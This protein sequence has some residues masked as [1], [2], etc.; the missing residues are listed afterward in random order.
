VSADLESRLERV[1]DERYHHL[2][3]FNLR[4]HAGE[5]SRAEIRTWV[6]NRYYYQTRIPKKDGLIVTK[7]DDPAFRRDWTRRIRDHEGEAGRE[8]GLELWL[9]L[10]EAVGLDREQVAMCRDVL[11]G[12]RRACDAY[13]EFVASHDLLESVAASL[14]ERRA[15]AIMAVRIEAWEK[16][17]SWVTPDGLAYFRSRTE[18]APRD[19]R[20]GLAY[21]LEHAQNLSDADRCVAALE[22]KC[23]ILWSLLDAIEW[24][25]RAPSLTPGM[26][27]RDDP[28]GDSLAV[29]AERAVRLND[30]GREILE[31]CGEGRSICEV[32]AAFAT[33]HPN[34][35][36]ASEDAYA[37][38]EAME[39]QRVIRC[40]PRA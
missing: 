2:H 34:E 37:F 36:N 15:G 21:V 28:E 27:L 30:T 6:A 39:S 40:A 12:V 10:S 32:G 8:G 4:M 31:L 13:V 1:L 9:R 7:A 3:P 29:G 11:P 38:L 19:A 14:T 23:E 17:Y 25:G 35:T 5:L 33:R 18:Q 16:H 22:R 24:G 20:E 26:R